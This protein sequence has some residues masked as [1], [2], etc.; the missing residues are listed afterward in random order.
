MKVLIILGSESDI[1]QVEGTKKLLKDFKVPFDLVV[2]SAHR[3]PKEV[4]KIAASAEIEI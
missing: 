2:A 3:K 4:M 1:P